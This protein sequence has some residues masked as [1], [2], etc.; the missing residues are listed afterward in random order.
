MATIGEQE[1]TDL[2]DDDILMWPDGFWCYRGDLLE[3]AKRDYSYRVL[4]HQCEQW[5][6]LNGLRATNKL[7]VSS[8]FGA[9]AD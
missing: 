3:C 8:A 7:G 9:D 5:Q 1:D 4:E 6:N 2:N